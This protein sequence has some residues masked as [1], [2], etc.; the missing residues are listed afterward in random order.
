MKTISRIV[1]K[2]NDVFGVIAGLFIVA[3]VLMVGIEIIMRSVFNSTIYITQ[4]YSGYFMVAITFFGIAYT[5]KEKGHIRLNFLHRFIKIGLGRSILEIIV[6]LV[7][8]AIFIVVLI[9]TTKLFMSSLENGSRSMQ[10]TKTYLAIPQSIMPLGALLICLQFISEILKQI[11][12]IKTG[13][14]EPDDTGEGE[15]GR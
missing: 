2:V 5:L 4:E 1:D 10:I 7:G 15:L 13:E 14:Y 9:A 11:V 12:Q 6:S 3:S 8:L